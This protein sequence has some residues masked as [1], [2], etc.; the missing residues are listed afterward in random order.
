M[1]DLHVYV[2]KPL[3]NLQVRLISAGSDQSFEKKQFKQKKTFTKL[4]PKL[5]LGCLNNTSLK[6][7]VSDLDYVECQKL[8]LGL[9]FYN[10]LNHVY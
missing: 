8:Y 10:C 2:L 7:K 3:L 1:N 9:L 5:V 6:P 4:K